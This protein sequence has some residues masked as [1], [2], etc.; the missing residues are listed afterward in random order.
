MKTAF[1]I[2]VLLILVNLKAK[3]GL[4]PTTLGGQQ[5]AAKAT[6]FNFK[7]PN[8]QAT[9]T[10]GTE[11]LIE[12]GNSNILVNPSFEHATAN[13]SWTLTAGSFV[14]DNS[15]IEGV[16]N[17]Q[18]TM[19]A[20]SLEF[21]QD[22]TLYASQFADGVQGLAYARVR[23]TITS[24]PIYV[25]PRNA[26]AFPSV[27]TS[28]CVAVSPDGKWGLYKVPFILGAT[29]NGIGLTSNAV[30]ITG[31]IEMDG[32]FVGAPDVW[33]QTDSSKVAGE[34]YF[35]GTTNCA[36]W[37]RTS[38]TLGGFAS[39]VD[40]PGPTI[41]SSSVGSW[42]T[43]DS[44]LPRVTVNSLPAGTYKAKF[45]FRNNISVAGATLFSIHD[46]T[47]TCLPSAGAATVSYNPVVI[48]CVFVYTDMGNRSF[49]L[50]AAS[51]ANTINVPNSQTSPALGTRFILE[52]FDNN[53]T[54]SASCGARCM[55]EFSAKVSAT[56]VVSDEGVDWINGSFAITS[57][58]VFTGQFVS[59]IFTVEPN[60]SVTLKGSTGE[61]YKGTLSS[62]SQLVYQTMN[63]SGAASALSA[64]ISCKKTGAD[65]N[66]T[67]TI[68]G[69]FKEVMTAPGIT[70]PRTC[71]IWNGGASSSTA[72]SGT[73]CTEYFDG[74][75]TASACTRSGTGTYSCTYGNNTFTANSLVTC[76]GSTSSYDIAQK[77]LVA[78]SNGST[79]A[80]SIVTRNSSGIAT[81]SYFSYSCEGSA[82]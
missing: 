12:T 44:N 22:S 26:G 24:T 32:A 23:T 19:S 55:E 69:S 11:S 39:D 79:G 3:A 74:C 35:A 45:Y 25:C 33:Q 51:A 78:D 30:S 81:D 66:A 60:C 62:S 13:T 61:I 6:T 27:L 41:L 50:F 82:P 7:A 47:T 48:E 28:G 2:F 76:K 56:G 37:D 21:Y 31:D 73:P 57:T 9:Q 77:A 18:L 20:Q 59:N 70:K 42:Q 64:E 68:V 67:R 58:S 71:T 8:Y 29:S 52:Y 72:C 10:L 15:P 16:K 63:S 36:G 34:A 40:C 53:Q 1:I 65:L 54:Y 80:I 49:E 75:Q 17:A 14:S 43:T 46:G 4:P 5:S 38:S